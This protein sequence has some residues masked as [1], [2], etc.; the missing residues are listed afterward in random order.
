MDRAYGDSYVSAKIF[1]LA[2]LRDYLCI[3]VKSNKNR[4]KNIGFFSYLFKL[5][6]QKEGSPIGNYINE[7]IDMD[8]F[9]LLE[10]LAQNIDFSPGNINMLTLTLGILQVLLENARY[11]TGFD[12]FELNKKRINKFLNQVIVKT[13]IKLIVCNQ[14]SLNKLN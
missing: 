6:D 9:T 14:D 13:L 4:N 5:D 1:L 7:Q 3:P 12:Y 11:V 8:I 10:S 2:A